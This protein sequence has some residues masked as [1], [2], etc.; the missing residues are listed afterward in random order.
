M[1]LSIW[2]KILLG[3]IKSLSYKTVRSNNVSYYCICIRFSW[4]RQF[5]THLQAVEPLLHPLYALHLAGAPLARPIAC[6]SRWNQILIHWSNSL[7][8]Q[9]QTWIKTKPPYYT[10]TSLFLCDYTTEV[11]QAP[12][13]SI[14]RNLQRLLKPEVTWKIMG[15]STRQK[16]TSPY[17]IFH[18]SVVPFEDKSL[19]LL[20]PRTTARRRM[21]WRSPRKRKRDK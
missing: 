5:F 17:D 6:I 1:G 3:I 2:E 15:Y 11:S 7:S 12:A 14:A 16:E 20:S 8:D 18:S 19:R 9:Q 10:L 21:R 4:S 13:L